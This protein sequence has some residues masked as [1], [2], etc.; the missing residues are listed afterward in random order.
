MIATCPV[1]ASPDAMDVARL[2]AIPVLCNSLWPDRQSALKADRA[3]M[4]LVMC[5]NCSHLFNADFDPGILAYDGRYDTTLTHS[6]IFSSY[7]EETAMRLVRS[8]DLVN[9]HVLE[10][11]CGQ[12]Y[13]LE[14][15]INHGAAT[16]TGFDPSYRADTSVADNPSLKIHS[17]YFSAGQSSPTADLACSRHVLEHLES[18]LDG[19]ELLR[20][21]LSPSGRG[22]VYA[23]VPNGLWTLE[24]GGVWDLIYEH[25]SYF[26]PTSLQY[27]AQRAGLDVI[28]LEPVFG[29]QFLGMDARIAEDARSE[30]P[31][32]DELLNK[33]SDLG[34]TITDL[35]RGWA[36][37]IVKW[38]SVGRDIALWGAGSKG[39]T[40]LN[41]VDGADII[42]HVVDISPTKFGRYVPGTGQEIIPPSR[43][44][45]SVTGPLEVICMNPNYQKE[46]AAELAHLGVDATLHLV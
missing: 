9:C 26:T 22:L 19:L 33:A 27:L 34:E 45:G 30:T 42:E 24:M 11:G 41:I 35:R 1:C 5:A 32:I 25:V 16:G 23:E 18:P 28:K 40:F 17:R 36:E 4:R 8:Y 12:G 13:F 43:L 3:G 15:L 44:V 6:A 46:I 7:V 2:E 39:V 10:M 38:R 14:R 20:A 21:S 31:S 37:R 29:S